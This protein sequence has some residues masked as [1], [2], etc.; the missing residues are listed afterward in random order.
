MNL[1]LRVLARLPK[2][3]TI[4]FALLLAASVG[5]M[6]YGT[7]YEL[8]LTALY[9]VPVC[10]AT[11]SAGRR[12]GML[13]AVAATLIWALADLVTGH[14]YGHPLIPV[15]NSLMLFS[16]FILAV[17]TLTSALEAFRSLMDAQALLRDA[18]EHLEETV[19]VR[20]AALKREIIERQRVQEA[21][22]QAERLLERSEKL[23]VLGTLTAG[24]AHEIRNPLTSIKARL[25]TLEKRLQELPAA[26][27]DTDIINAELSR[28]ERIVQ[29]ALSFA[30][31]AEPKLE[32]SSANVILRDI[33]SLMSGSLESR[34]VKLVVA[35]GPE[36]WIRADSGH[37]KQVLI[38]LIRNAADAIDG[39]GTIQL[40]ARPERTVF[41]GQE[42]DV[43]R[44]EVTDS[45]CG[46]SPEAEKRLFDPFFTTKATGTGLGL[47]IA[48]RIVEKHGGELQYRPK[49]DQGTTF[50][51]VLPRLEAEFTEN[52]SPV[53]TP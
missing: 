36:L 53:A 45:G 18:N 7:G 33:Q 3:W 25:Y 14:S 24:I 17:T 11:W 1:A 8:H 50:T 40:R 30:Q 26:R 42:T 2:A 29:D 38:N 32:R 13:V 21:K 49:L 22:V 19:Q 37:L 23:A 44:I 31:P 39:S 5:A 16:V 46:M 52:N 27:K 51:I 48:A 12:A 47:P 6:D 4:V 35:A 34:Q 41:R 20:T 43:V 28:L 10:W 15:W 9:L